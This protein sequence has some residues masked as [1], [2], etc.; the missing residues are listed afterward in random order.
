MLPTFKAKLL[1]GKLSK[2][3]KIFGPGKI[4][5]PLGCHF[6]AQNRNSGSDFLPVQ[7]F[8]YVGSSGPMLEHNV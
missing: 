6:G 3:R 4:Q 8:L 5:F 2:D 1:H 7:R